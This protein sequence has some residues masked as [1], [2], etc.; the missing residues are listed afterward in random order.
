MTAVA[1]SRFLRK[2]RATMTSEEIDDVAVRREVLLRRLNV[3]VPAIAN[4]YVLLPTKRCV[5][6]SWMIGLSVF[7][8]AGVRRAAV[9]GFLPT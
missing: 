4:E 3:T 6:R 5:S 2:A 1:T 8:A 9:S 7:L